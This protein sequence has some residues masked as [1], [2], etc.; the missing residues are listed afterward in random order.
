M[1]KYYL[2]AVYTLTS[3][4]GKILTELL[5]KFQT[6]K[7]IWQAFD[8]DLLEAYP[9][10]Q[11]IIRN[12][13]A[14]R[15]AK[16]NYPEELYT[17]CYQKGVKIATKFEAEIFPS[18]L[19]AAEPD[20]YILFYKGELRA[21]DKRIAVVGSRNITA[22]GEIV[23]TNIGRDLARDG[24]TVVSGGAYGVDCYSH[25]GAL[26]YGRTELVL[27]CGIDLY[28]PSAH[29]KLIDQVAE[30]G[31]VVSEYPPGV[32]ATNYTFP[33]RNRI[34]SG[35]SLGTVVVEAARKS[36]SLITAKYAKKQGRDLF[37]VPG[38]IFSEMSVGTNNL[39]REGAKLITAGTDIVAALD[40]ELGPMPSLFDDAASGGGTA[41]PVTPTALTSE[42]TRQGE[43]L[44]EELPRPVR[45]PRHEVKPAK[46]A[47][48]WVR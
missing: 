44:G 18:L 26:E 48:H 34:I 15:K 28:Y 3:S 7:A 2:A 33:A 39:I 13:L 41:N 29:R 9:K 11:R 42:L 27:G 5:P 19:P 22:Y 1:D 10:N 16:P 37:A 12:F 6:A 24:I 38:D 35:M 14:K 45:R 21:K 46:R 32:R 36:G 47:R 25:R 23:A 31:A 8:D 40:N 30:V 20:I 4:G 43:E 17:D